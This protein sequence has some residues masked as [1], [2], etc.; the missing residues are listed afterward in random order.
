[1]VRLPTGELQKGSKDAEFAIR[2][3][4]IMSSLLHINSLN[5]IWMKLHGRDAFHP[6][7]MRRYDGV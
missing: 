6:C 4:L 3:Q 5:I 2:H 1:M 7:M